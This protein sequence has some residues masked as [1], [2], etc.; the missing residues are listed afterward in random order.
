MISWTQKDK[1]AWRPLPELD[2][3]AW[4]REHLYLSRQTSSM[5]G[6]YRPE[7][8][9]YVLEPLSCFTDEWVEKIVL[10][11]AAQTG[12]TTLIYACLSYAIAWDPGPIL[13]VMPAQNLCDYASANRIQPLIKQC[14][15]LAE[16]FE[17]P[18]RWRLSEMRFDGGV[19][20]LVGANSPGQLSSRP[21]RYLLLDETSKY[22]ITTGRE[23]S[24]QAL[25]EERTN[26]FPMHKILAASTPVAEG[27]PILSD[28]ADS[29]NRRYQVPCPRCGAYQQLQQDQLRWP[30]TEQGKSVEP[31]EAR[32]DT[33]YQCETC[34]GK[35]EDREKA[36]M[37]AAGKWIRQGQTID[38]AGKIHGN[39][40]RGSVAGFQLSAFYSPFISWGQLVERWLRGQD[41]KTRLQ[42]Y[43]NSVLA[44]PW[45]QRTLT[46]REDDISEHVW[47]EM[48]PGV[49]PDGYEILTGA[50][51]VQLAFVRYNVWA[52]RLDGAR[53]LVEY[54]EFAGIDN[55]EA[56]TEATWQTVDGREIGLE[57]FFLDSGYR[58][59]DVYN[60]ARGRRNVMACKGTTSGTRGNYSTSQLDKYPD[61]KPIKGGLR[62]VSIYVDAYKDELHDRL[63][64]GWPDEQKRD[65]PDPPD[66]YIS[67]HGDTGADYIKPLTAE[68]RVE[69]TDIRG[70]VRFEWVRKHADNHYFDAAVYASAAR[71]YIR[72]SYEARQKRKQRRQARQKAADKAMARKGI[73]PTSKRRRSEGFVGR[74]RRKG[75]RWI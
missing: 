70:Q 24:P 1:S 72:G 66:R 68:V 54:G 33:W 21:V 58:T 32:A 29:D 20:S 22:P 71:S 45:K 57:M 74:S 62:L 10:C 34:E 73:D 11:W 75:G 41:D 6:F 14:P 61:G 15:A 3:A 8:T 31:A 9:P 44:Q 67:F 37:L 52:W 12:K 50:A 49:I 56:V 30:H 60:F 13:I 42:S 39:P 28:L 23:A 43:V 48:A 16:K 36:P 25:A 64:I 26:S 4:S 46:P 18:R 27:D 63:E 55:L 38:P 59:T 7:F 47:P 35:I 51:D 65:G 40:P 2:V 5:P 53:H 19:L 69:K 17:P